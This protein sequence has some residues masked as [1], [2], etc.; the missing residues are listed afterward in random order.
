MG[1]GKPKFWASWEEILLVWGKF[2]ISA[3]AQ[4]PGMKAGRERK[5]RMKG[6]EPGG[7]S[8]SPELAGTAHWEP[9]HFAQHPAPPPNTFLTLCPGALW[10]F[11]CFLWGFVAGTRPRGTAGSNI[12]TSAGTI[13]GLLLL[14]PKRDTKGSPCTPSSGAAG[15]IFL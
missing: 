3:A 1:G 8:S 5:R 7:G 4:S 13:W 10:G 14:S 12:S 11:G 15:F 9:K 2:R 6:R